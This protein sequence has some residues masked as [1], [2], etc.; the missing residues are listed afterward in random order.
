MS[1]F[2]EVEEYFSKANTSSTDKNVN[3][4]SNLEQNYLFDGKLDNIEEWLQHEEFRL[5]KKNQDSERALREENA[6]KAFYFSIGWAVFVCFIII[7]KS[8]SLWGVQLNQTEFLATIGT[9][10]ITILTYYLVVIKYLFPNNNKES[11]K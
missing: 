4:Q 8:F 3:E 1:N 5:K 2:K 10:S 7:C 11:K 6:I 9:L